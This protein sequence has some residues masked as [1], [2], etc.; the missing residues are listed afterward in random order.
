VVAFG[1]RYEASYQRAPSS[2]AAEAFD[3]T[4]L[5]LGAA[6]AGV[7]DR[8]G[9]IEALFREPRRAGVSGALEIGPDGEV[10]RRPHLLG[11]SRGEVVSLD[12]MALPI[13]ESGAGPFGTPPASD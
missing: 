8:K 6:A 9:L 12:D 13:D 3:A 5:V 2:L 4:N 1:E 7:E 11:V 10:A